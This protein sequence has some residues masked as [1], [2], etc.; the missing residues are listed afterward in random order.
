MTALS[1]C[2][3]AETV[4]TARS[5]TRISDRR[6]PGGGGEQGVAHQHGDRHEA[7]AA[8]HRRDRGGHRLDG[9]EV[10]VA[11]QL[12]G[13]EAV[14]A[15]VDHP[16]ARLDHV[17]GDHARPAGRHAQDVGAPRVAGE[18]AG[19]RVTHR[20]RGVAREQELGE[21]L[22]D[23]ARASDHHRLGT[24]QLRAVVVEDLDAAGRRAR[25]G[26]RRAGQQP[27]EVLGM[28]TVG[29]L[30]G[31]QRRD[32]LVLVQPLGQRQLDQHAVDRAIGVEP[33]HQVEQLALTEPGG[34]DEV[35]R[36]D[37]DAV[38]RALLVAHVDLRGGIVTDQHDGQRG[39][40]AAGRLEAL[41]AGAHVAEHLL[42]HRLAVEDQREGRLT[43]ARVAAGCRTRARSRDRRR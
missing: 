13:V 15:D 5:G 11:G 40:D 37:A 33:A 22:A 1:C 39:R 32:D 20:D 35:L 9:V 6:R 25:H 21:R 2:D 42:G 3:S 30:R 26:G 12:A 17:A 10:H 24:F 27:A 31:C 19:A 38:G 16:R 34:V 18:I 14:D 28:Q 8:R 23:Q 41:D 7:D 4:R 29:V 36:G 43:P